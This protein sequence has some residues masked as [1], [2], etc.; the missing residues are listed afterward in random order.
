MANALI[1][2]FMRFLFT[3][4]L[5]NILSK[6]LAAFLHI[7]HQQTVVREELILFESSERILA[8]PKDRISDL[9]F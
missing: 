4:A 3:S 6:P 1:H 9:C 2:A 8:E 5:H 7:H